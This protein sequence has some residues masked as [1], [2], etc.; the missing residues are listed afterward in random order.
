[1]FGWES[2][3]TAFAS[4]S[5]RVTRSRSVANTD[6]S[7]LIATS[8]SSRT[9]RARYTSP[10][11]PAPRART[12]SYGPSVVPGLSATV[13]LRGGGPYWDGGIIA[14]VHRFLVPFVDS[15]D[16]L[17]LTARQIVMSVTRECPR[18]GGRLGDAAS[19]RSSWP[20]QGRDRPADRR[21]DRRDQGHRA[22]RGH[23]RAGQLHADRRPRSGD[24][25]GLDA[26][27]RH[28]RDPHFVGP[29][30]V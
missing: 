6:G 26:G 2:A 21:G 29:F 24:G 3:A 4:R 22:I 23:R 8:R 18:A 20:R 19:V 11:P 16:R 7:T 25:R 5:K 9:S 14:A 28:A 15:P 27:I 10:M 17:R 13:R 12:T 30:Q 1:M